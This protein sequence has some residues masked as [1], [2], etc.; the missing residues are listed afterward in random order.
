M[1]RVSFS[2]ERCKGCALCV[3]ACPKKIIAMSETTY[4]SK[5][6]YV[7][8]CINQSACI[9]CAFCAVMC[10]DAVITVEK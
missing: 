1:A 10:P 9:G 5:G 6:F 3:E 2:E 8:E 4:N 7:A